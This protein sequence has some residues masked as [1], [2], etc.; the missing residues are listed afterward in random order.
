[1]VKLLRATFPASIEVRQRIEARG[2][3][4]AD[5][6]QLHQV[7]MNLATTARQAMADA[8]TLEI[9]LSRVEPGASLPAGLASVAYFVLSVADSGPGMT[10]EVRERIFEPFFTT[11][12]VGEGTGLGLA[13][14]HGIV[15]GHGGAILCESEPGHGATFRVYLTEARTAAEKPAASVA[16][17]PGR[18]LRVVFVDDDANVVF[19]GRSLLEGLGHEVT[20]A[21][22]G[23]EALQL[24]ARDPSACDLLIVDEV[25]PRMTGSQLCA[26]VR[27][28]RPD[29][30]VIVASGHGLPPGALF[31]DDSAVSYLPKPFDA[32]ELAQAVDAALAGA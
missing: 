20:T 31:A 27:R 28:L 3:V 22:S 13:V 9:A 14:A 15:K 26:E 18:K 10:P 7:L 23:T 21:A 17:S 30:P 16:T 2:S 8:G 19:V 24:V 5:P 25:M 32:A 29:L 4:V 1:V 11:K 12:G 6:S